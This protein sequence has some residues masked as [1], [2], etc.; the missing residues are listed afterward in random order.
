MEDQVDILLHILGYGVVV[1]ILFGI[2]F[3]FVKILTLGVDAI[4]DHDD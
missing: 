1:A 3:L 2:V 4:S